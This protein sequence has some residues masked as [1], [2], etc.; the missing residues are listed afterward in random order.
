MPEP[1]VAAGQVPAEAF[2]VLGR[3]LAGLVV[4]DQLL[5]AREVC[6]LGQIPASRWARLEPGYLAAGL[7]F[8]VVSPPGS[9]RMERRY[10]RMSFLG[11]VRSAR[12]EA[13]AVMDRAK[14]GAG[15]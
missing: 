14:A 9:A 1:G 5:T 10:S 11:L 13:Q 15:L 6:A 8:I 7:R 3:R 2:E 12:D 4:E